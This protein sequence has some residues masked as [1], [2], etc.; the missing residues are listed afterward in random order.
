MIKKSLPL[1]L[2]IMFFYNGFGQNNPCAENF[3]ITSKSLEIKSSNIPEYI[4]SWNF[5]K[6]ANKNFLVSELEI[7]PLNGCWKSLNGTKRSEKIIHKIGSL[8][9]KSQG[10][11]AVSF[12]DLNAKCFKWRTKIVNTTTNCESFTDWQFFSFL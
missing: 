8:S 3:L 10:E 9:K 5:T 11:F 6:T 2:L 12:K 1:V 4:I 7:Q